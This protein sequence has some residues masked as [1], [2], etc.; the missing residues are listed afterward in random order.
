MSNAQAVSKHFRYLRYVLR[1]K[2]YVLQECWRFGIRWR[3]L[4]HDLSKFSPAEWGP[5]ADYF[6][7]GDWPPYSE[8]PGEWKRQLGDKWTKE[9]V[10]RRFDRAW[11]H[12]IHRNPHHWQHWVLREDSGAT[13]VLDMPYACIL[14]MIADWFGAGRAING[15]P[16]DDNPLMRYDE[17]RAWYLA[18][19]D[20]MQLGDWTRNHVEHLIGVP[21]EQRSHFVPLQGFRPPQ[22]R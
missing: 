16:E 18:N 21:D 1:H 13:K 17:L 10:Q 9:W 15:P 2:W 8:T 4:V 20:K 14:E 19:R 22:Y 3:G 5:Y 11:L 12:H 6:Y 7:G